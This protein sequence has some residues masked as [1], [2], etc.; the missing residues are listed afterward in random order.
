MIKKIGYAC[1]S[2]NLKP[3]GFKEC[4]LNSVYKFGID[5]LREKI[6]NNL[7]LTRDIL[8][9]NVENG[10]FMYRATSTLLPL[11][12]HSDVKRDFSWRWQQD[13]EICLYMNEIKEVVEE[14]HIRLS[15]H[16]DQFTVLN[17]LNPK[18]VENSIQYLQY[19]YEVLE[20]LGGTD[21]IIHTGGVYGNKQASM[22]RFI[23]NYE[24]LNENIKKMLRLENDDV[25]YTLKDV[26]YINEKCGIPIVLDIHHH[27]CNNEKPLTKQ[28]MLQIKNSW[29]STSL[30]P[31]MHISSGKTNFND[32]K[33]SD[34]IRY[35]D[36]ENLKTLLE[37]ID[38]DLMIE[39]KMKDE[40]VLE[41]MKYTEK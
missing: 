15:M 40:A 26:L 7:L 37:N 41:I 23:E 39:A 5:Y 30:I 22:D 24:K 8:K 29:N 3:R 28:Y 16:P 9:W 38:I 13:E 12:T 34:Y 4:R 2:L 6:I 21:M 14:N 27:N 10:I 31:K 19:H 18:V 25:S 35:E 17:S 33:H 20:K 1:I 32:K 36:L 11:V